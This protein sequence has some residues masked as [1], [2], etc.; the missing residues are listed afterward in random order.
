[1][2]PDDSEN[3]CRRLNQALATSS[4][5][6]AVWRKCPEAKVEEFRWSGE[7]THE[8]RVAGAKKSSVRSY[9]KRA[10]MIRRRKFTRRGT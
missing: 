3:F 7:N 9:W 2:D 5:H 6:D 8:D 4:L 1:M 10:D